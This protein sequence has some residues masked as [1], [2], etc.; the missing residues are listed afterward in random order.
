MSKIVVTYASAGAGHF[1]AAE[2][3][4][5]YLKD[6]CKDKDVEIVDILDKTSATFRF[7]YIAGYNFIVRHCTYIWS[8]IFRLTYHKNLHRVIRPLIS[9]INRLN[10]RKFLEFLIRENP[11]YIISTHF[12]P[13]EIAAGLK[14]RNKI[15]SGII[16]IVTDFVVHP[17]WICEGTDAYIVASDLTKEDLLSKGVGE[18]RIKVK[19]IPVNQKFLNNPEK[20]NLRRKLNIE[21]KF[22]ILLVTGSF[23]IGPIER[24]VELLRK[25]IQVLAVCANNYALYSRLKAK[26]YPSVFVFGVAGNMEE[27]MSVSDIIITKAGGL[28]ISEMLIKELVPVFISSIPGQETGNAEILKK[29]GI[30]ITAR[31]ILEVRDIVLDYK[32]HPEK[33]EAVR[34][35]IKNIKKPFAVQ[36]LSRGIC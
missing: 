3:V 4:F 23:G 10:S 27:L 18:D 26:A 2:A 1:K 29:Y 13:S 30:G 31:D 32:N 5:D 22:T 17:L 6:V 35:N 19:G 20:D 33:L 9:L 21:N 12:F 11:Q 7:S 25:D 16:S 28:T 36:E 8:L 34:E 15:S 24:I 14:A